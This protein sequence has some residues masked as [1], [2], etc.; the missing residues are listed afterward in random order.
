MVKKKIK[1]QQSSLSS[2]EL[3]NVTAGKSKNDWDKR[4]N[5]AF[6]LIKDINIKE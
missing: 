2:E 4:W 6:N 1:K 3:K 5:E